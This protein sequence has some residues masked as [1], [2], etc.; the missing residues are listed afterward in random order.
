M[1]PPVC[2][3]LSR[4]PRKQ[5]KDTMHFLITGHT[6]FKGAWLTLL[7]VERGHTV[8]GVSLDPPANS[9]FRM[10]R[11]SEFLKHDITRDVRDYSALKKDIER[12][13]PDFLI[14]MAAQS[15]VRKSYKL[16]LETFETNVNGTLNLLSASEEIS[17]LRG[18]LVITTDKVYKNFDKI[19]GYTESDPLGGSDPY[20]ASKSM[21]DIATQSWS[22]TFPKV[23]TAIARA[24]NVIG[25]GDFS[26]DRLIPDIIMELGDNKV[27]KLRFPNSIRPWQH[28]L[29]CLNGYL[30]LV[31]NMLVL[32]TRGEWNF[33]PKKEVN[34]SVGQVTSKILELWGTIPNW[35][36]TDE[37]NPPESNFLAL[38]S[39]KARLKLGWQ[40]KLNFDGAIGWTVD[41]YKR[42]REGADPLTE[43]VSQIRE[44]E[45][46]SS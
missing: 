20:S 33:G 5:A 36:E 9:L 25:G 23:P 8:S 40:D 32:K 2:D 13:K 43:T 15:L 22:I 28:V 34:K 27:P 29:D 46:R 45:S 12:V 42:V 26:E 44:F 17:N 4:I 18:R 19:E 37:V 35:I 14:H 30:L 24:G 41:W 6:G 21:A 7:L 38:D 11:V 10:A 1:L 16:P 3:L 31:D 39:S